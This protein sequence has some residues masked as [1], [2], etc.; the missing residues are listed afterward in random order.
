MIL[1]IL[2]HVC[3]LN[4]DFGSACTPGLESVSFY[5][6]PTQKSCKA[7][8]YRG[9]GGND[10]RFIDADQCD[11]FCHLSCKFTTSRNFGKN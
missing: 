7:F 2:D 9:C 10:N 3:A 5:F 1:P 6:D 11:A 8:R 4:A